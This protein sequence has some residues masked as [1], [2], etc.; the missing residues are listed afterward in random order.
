MATPEGADV[1]HHAALAT[2]NI[3]RCFYCFW[4]KERLFY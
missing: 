3:G 1:V 2:G 4:H